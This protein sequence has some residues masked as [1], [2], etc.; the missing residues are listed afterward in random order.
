MPSPPELDDLYDIVCNALNRHIARGISGSQLDDMANRAIRNVTKAARL[1]LYKLNTNS[2]TILNVFP[3]EIF[4]HIASMLP[5]VERMKLCT[6]SQACK[7][8]LLTNPTLWSHGRV[9]TPHELDCM[10]KYHG[11]TLLHVQF[12]LTNDQKRTNSFYGE[13]HELEPFRPTITE[14]ALTSLA[15]LTERFE[16][17]ALLTAPV[18]SH[19]WPHLE[20]L[21]LPRHAPIHSSIPADLPD[22]MPRL[23]ELQLSQFSIDA[24]ATP[25]PTLRVFRGTYDIRTRQQPLVGAPSILHLM[26]CLH[27]LDLR[28]VTN[29]VLQDLGSLDPP[30]TLRVLVLTPLEHDVPGFGQ[31]TNNDVDYGLLH[32]ALA[33]SRWLHHPWTAVSL[34]GSFSFATPLAMLAGAMQEPIAMSFLSYSTPGIAEASFGMDVPPL[35]TVIAS[36][37]YLHALELNGTAACSLLKSGVT[38]PKTHTFKLIIT[39]YFDGEVVFHEARSKDVQLNE[40]VPSLRNVSVQC[41]IEPFFGKLYRSEAYRAQTVIN[42]LTQDLPQLLAPYATHQLPCFE[43]I[44]IWVPQEELEE[45]RKLSVHNLATLASDFIVNSEPA[46]PYIINSW[47]HSTGGLLNIQ[48]STISMRCG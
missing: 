31:R 35:P 28:A 10:L 17:L 48:A 41:A 25:I 46:I 42:W 38:L 16:S 21:L 19:K 40:R 14:E 24:N 23:M 45:A 13:P 20:H 34:S 2:R 9:R 36:L 37:V 33:T 22:R 11:A 7:Y 30:Q 27:T 4:A 26:P 32:R 3:G 39:D 47:V 29:V 15:P 8:I 18:F 1:T 43:R 6:V 12:S 5:F 44:T